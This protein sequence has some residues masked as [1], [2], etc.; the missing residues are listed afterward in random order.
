MAIV[1]DHWELVVQLVDEGGNSTTRRFQFR[2]SDDAGDMSDLLT[3]GGALLTDLAAVSDAVIKKV[4]YN[5]VMVEGVFAL[6]EEGEVEEH[7][8]ITAPINGEPLKSA[9]I[10][11]PAPKDTIFIG[12]PGDGESFN[13]VD[14][15]DGALGNYL[16]LFTGGASQFLVS[17]GEAIVQNN[18]RGK[19]THSRSTGG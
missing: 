19:R 7:A 12:A 9:T 10:D 16:G 11:I 2:A 6:P 1:A 17:D 5:K 3:S 18:M 15:N 13:Q 4:S 8:L 14:F